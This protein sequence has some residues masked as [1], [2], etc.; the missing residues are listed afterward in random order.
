MVSSRHLG[1]LRFIDLFCGI[2]GMRLAFEAAGC[3]CVF[4]SDWDK[5]AQVTYKENFGETP[6]GDIRGVPA[7]D[8]P[9]HDI[10][11]AGFPCQPFSI[12]GVSKKNSL[13]KRT[14][15]TTRRRAPSSSRSSG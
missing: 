13:N 6:T 9:D 8:I 14:A 10:L 12:S 5:H 3:D 4:S 11:V 2:G 15:S 7:S 1:K